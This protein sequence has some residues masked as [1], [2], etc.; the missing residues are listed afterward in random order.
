MIKRRTGVLEIKWN[1]WKT[2]T[3]VSRFSETSKTYNIPKHVWMYI[4]SKTASAHKVEETGEIMMPTNPTY[5]LKSVWNCVATSFML[6]ASA[7]VNTQYSLAELYLYV[8]LTSWAQ[9]ITS[10]FA[11]DWLQRT[12]P[13]HVPSFV[14]CTGADLRW[15]LG[16]L[17]GMAKSIDC[18]V[19][20]FACYMSP[21]LSQ[22]HR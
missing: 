7:F 8:Y 18:Q 20:T 13:P 14:S 12:I 21:P 16:Q 15:F 5:R 22:C 1:G 6:T 19:E 17:S 4:Y 9:F 2:L 11:F 3:N 10:Q